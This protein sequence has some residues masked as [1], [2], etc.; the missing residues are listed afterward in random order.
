MARSCQRPGRPTCRAASRFSSIA[1]S[2]ARP[3]SAKN[4]GRPES[5]IRT[6]RGRNWKVSPIPRVSGSSVS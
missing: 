3:R 5:L 6:L 4:R 1:V 2:R